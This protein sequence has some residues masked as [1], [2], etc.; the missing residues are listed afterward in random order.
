MLVRLCDDKYIKTK[1]CT[2]YV[3]A[4]RQMLED[5]LQDALDGVDS[6]QDW[7]NKYYW[8]E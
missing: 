4:F 2:S 7:R 6:E 5:G 8:T 1:K 3:E